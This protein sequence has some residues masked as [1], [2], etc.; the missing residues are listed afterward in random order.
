MNA[1]LPAPR[2]RAL[3]ALLTLLGALCL[4]CAPAQG[5]VLRCTDPRTG[6]VSYTDGAC[7]A[8]RQAKEVVP[9][10]SPEEIARDRERT[11][12]ALARKEQQQR[13]EAAAAAARPPPA[14]AR[15]PGPGETVH[16]A[17]SRQQLQKLLNQPGDDAQAYSL[18]IA[19][20]QRQMELDCLGPQAYGELEQSRSQQV[21]P[22]APYLFVPHRPQR[23]APPVRPQPRPEITQCNVFRCYD[24]QGNIYPR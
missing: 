6:A 2:P 14:P 22:T 9:A 23:P 18:Q 15:A 16:C 10:R 17:Q 3:P 11:A 19:A 8:G 20:A 1:L 13:E 5:Q 12:Q 7:D 4:A 21:S 24:R